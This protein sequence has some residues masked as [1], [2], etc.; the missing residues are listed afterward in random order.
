MGATADQDHLCPGVGRALD[1]PFARRLLRRLGLFVVACLVLGL[2][3]SWAV[4]AI[5]QHASGHEL[6]R[7]G[8]RSAGVVMHVEPGRKNVPERVDVRYVADRE[9]IGRVTV[10]AFGGSYDVG[11]EVTVVYDHNDPARMTIDGEANLGALAWLAVVHLGTVAVILLVSVANLT[12]R[13]GRWRRLLRTGRW[14]VYD[15]VGRPRPGSR[16][17][18]AL[19]LLKPAD[20]PGSPTQVLSVGWSYGRRSLEYLRET[21]WVLGDGRLVILATLRNGRIRDLYSARRPS[22]RRQDRRWR[23]RLPSI[24]RHRSPLLPEPWT[25]EPA[26]DPDAGRLPDPV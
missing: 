3:T 20:Q 18:N 16:G 10:D 5:V 24:V 17:N 25:A 4:L 15:G 12:L 23:R 14:R 19:V 11:D 21:V 26:P 7:D 6:R 2:A 8:V 9:R 1:D 22:T 13:L